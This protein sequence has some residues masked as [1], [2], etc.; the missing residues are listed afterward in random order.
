MEKKAEKLLRKDKLTPADLNTLT[1]AIER[2]LKSRRLM[3]GKSTDNT[4][5]N[6]RV[7]LVAGLMEAFHKGDPGVIDIEAIAEDDEVQPDG[8]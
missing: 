4:M 6:G 7:S 8:A 3:D 5:V 2:A 1:Q